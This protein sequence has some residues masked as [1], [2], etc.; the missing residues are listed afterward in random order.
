MRKKDG[1]IFF[2]SISSTSALDELGKVIHYDGII[3]DITERKNVRKKLALHQENLV[4]LSN[5]L[6]MAEEKVR[7]RLA[8]SVHDKLGQS[9]ALAN[10]KIN[11]LYKQT[12]NSEQKK[13]IDE[14]VAFVEESINESRNISY[15]LSPPVLYEMGLVPAIS[16]KLDDIE[17][18]N[19]IKTSLIDQSKSYEPEENVKIILYRTLNELL[20]NV[21]KHSKADN[22]N[23]SFKLLANDYIIT[24]TD[25]GIGFDLNT[26]RDKAVSQKKFGLFS[27]IE[28]IK[29][30]GGRVEIEATPRKGTKIIIK[31]PIKN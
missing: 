21:L 11:E 19:K 25:N 16:W 13:I 17:K 14:I 8:I 26:T 12:K 31:I 15:E 1:T 6:T 7:R 24:V 5:E 9:L 18:G 2:G 23:I 28:R 10:I 22:V 3:E 4:T 20:Q 30:I 27:I 29:Y